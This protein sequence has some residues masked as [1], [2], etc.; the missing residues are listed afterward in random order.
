M[1]DMKIKSEGNRIIVAVTLYNSD[2]IIQRC[3]G[4]IMSQS[5]DNFLC[6]ITDDLSK[7]ESVATVKDFIEDDDRFILIENK[8]KRYQGGNYDLICRHTEEV[9]DEDI[10]IEVDGDDWLPDRNVFQRVIDAYASG[11]IWITNGQFK[12]KNGAAGFSS[13]VT[14]FN[15][16]RKGTFTASHLRTW[17][18]FL[19][20]AI[21]EKDLRNPAGGWWAAAC[22]LIFMWD[23]LEMAGPDHYK[24]MTEVNY[25]YNDDNPFNEHKQYMPYIIDVQNHTKDKTPRK[26]LVR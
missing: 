5:Y 13:P 2:D 26:R 3:L 21:P 14:D 1:K 22:D 17:K 23:M 9:Q 16:I 18:A 20:R 15:T 25:V 6:Y 8:D 12:Y 10:I 19:W 7:D 11:D 4:S 24:F